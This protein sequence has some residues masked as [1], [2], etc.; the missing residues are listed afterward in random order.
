MASPAGLVYDLVGTYTL[1]EVGYLDDLTFSEVVVPVDVLAEQDFDGLDDAQPVPLDWNWSGSNFFGYNDWDGEMVEDESFSAPTSFWLPGDP[2]WT[3]SEGTITDIV[4]G[5]AYSVG[6]MYKG[7]LQFILE[8]GDLGYDLGT[9]PDGIIPADATVDE[10]SLVWNLE[11]TGWVK[12]SYAW[13]QGSWLA[14][15][16]VT[17]PASMNFSFVG[18]YTDGDHGYVDDL[19]VL[20]SKED[21]GADPLI[22]SAELT[23]DVYGID[24]ILY[25]TTYIVENSSNEILV[26]AD[27]E[28]EPLAIHWDLPAKADWTEWK[29]N[30]TNPSTDIG[31]TLT[32]KLNNEITATPDWISPEKVV[33][34]DAHAGWTYFDDFVYGI[35]EPIGIDKDLFRY[36]LKTYPNPASDVLYLSIQ[37]PLERI[38]V[39]NSLG[40]LQMDLDHPDRVLDIAGLN[41]GMYLIN[42]TDEQ[43]IVHNAKFIK[44]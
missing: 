1:D 43:G 4:D 15:A 12:F 40:Q 19:V 44:R 24:Y 21:V 25:D 10:G 16:S 14:D 37:I 39:Y 5:K 11:S 20:K 30:W 32:M 23:F 26:D 36:D 8:M 33:F 22:E 27:S 18:T 42:A 31:S 3:G 29:L 6:F 38:E 13:E 9:D 2:E 35:G 41:N 7:K 17:S 28:L 34:D